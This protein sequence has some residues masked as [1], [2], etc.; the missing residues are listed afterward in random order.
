MHSK[1]CFIGIFLLIVI[2]LFVSCYM[3]NFDELS[4]KVATPQ[5]SFQG[6]TTASSSYSYY[7]STDYAVFSISCKTNGAAIKYSIDDGETFQ[8]YDSNEYSY[9]SSDGKD[10]TGI[11]VPLK[12][13]IEVYAQKEGME[14]SDTVYEYVLA[15]S[16]PEVIN[17]GLRTYYSNYYVVSITADEGSVIKYAFNGTDP[18]AYGSVYN[19]NNYSTSSGTYSGILVPKGSILKVIA[20]DVGKYPSKVVSMSF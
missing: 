2:S 16:I 12:T 10:I 6:Y 18:E 19:P 1:I 11:K 14:N 15:T 9:Y 5:L 3:S 7:Y 8:D 20:I 4:A 13:S 17:H